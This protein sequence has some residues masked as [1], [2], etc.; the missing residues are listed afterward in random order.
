MCKAE[1]PIWLKSDTLLSAKQEQ[2]LMKPVPVHPQAALL[3][4]LDGWLA[5]IAQPLPI[6]SIKP[7]LENQKQSEPKLCG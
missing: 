7:L 6:H 2:T 1:C 5:V 3:P 4:G